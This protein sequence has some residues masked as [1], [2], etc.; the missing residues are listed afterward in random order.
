MQVR[1]GYRLGQWRGLL[2]V[3]FGGVGSGS[4]GSIHWEMVSKQ[5]LGLFHYFFSTTLHSYKGKDFF[6]VLPWKNNI[7]HI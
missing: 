7:T 1:A 4:G 2:A 6:L 3:A 5:A